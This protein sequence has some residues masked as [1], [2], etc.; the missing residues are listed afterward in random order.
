MFGEATSVKLLEKWPTTFKQ[1]II[2]ECQK[3]PAVNEMKELLLAADPPEDNPEE[4]Y[5]LGRF[6]MECS[7]SM[8]D[9]V[10]WHM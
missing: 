10:L 9:A 3:L 4:D 2:R 7:S 5:E 1:K 6:L 8:Q